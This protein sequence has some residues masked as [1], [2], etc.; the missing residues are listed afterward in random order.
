MDGRTREAGKASQ[1]TK[2]GDWISF[3][4]TVHFAAAPTVDV[5]ASKPAPAC[6]VAIGV[7]RIDAVGEQDAG[8]VEKRLPGNAELPAVEGNDELA[9][10]SRSVAVEGGAQDDAKHVGRRSTLSEPRP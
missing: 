8:G 3:S 10:Q 1:R 7:A 4:R 5:M 2:C 6:R 9:V